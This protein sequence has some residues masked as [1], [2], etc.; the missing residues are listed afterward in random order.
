MN[1]YKATL[2]FSLL[3]LCACSDD[4]INIHLTEIQSAKELQVITCSSGNR[5]DYVYVK[6]EDIEYECDGSEWVA[7][8][9]PSS[10]SK[11]KSSSGS[12][13]K[14][15]SSSNKSSSSESNDDSSSSE[16]KSSSSNYDYYERS[17]SSSSIPTREDY[18]NPNVS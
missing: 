15:S 18:L 12:N 9:E 1:K 6:D 8:E 11:G 17:S 4:E 2:A 10:D 13:S 3:A 5:G 14:E 7:K 16:K